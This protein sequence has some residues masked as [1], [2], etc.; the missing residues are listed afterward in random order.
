MMAVRFASA[1]A[2]DDGVGIATDD[3]VATDDGLRAA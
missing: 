3:R 2:A 1:V